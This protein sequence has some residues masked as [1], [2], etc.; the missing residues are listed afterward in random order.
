MADL[1]TLANVKRHLGPEAVAT[2][3]ADA[4]LGSLVTSSSQWVSGRLGRVVLETAFTEVRD[5][6]GGTRMLLDEC[7]PTPDEPTITVT[8]VTVDGET[9][10]ARPAVTLADPNP[11]GWVLRDSGIDLVGYTF[12]VGLRN[13]TIIYRVGYSATTSGTIP[14]APGPYTV[15]AAATWRE[16]IS[17]T[18]AG[19]A[20]TKVTG[21]PAAGQYAVAFS[22]TTG[23]ATYTFN[24]ADTGKAVVLTFGICPTD[25]EQ[26]VIEHVALRYLDRRH[27]G[28]ASAS[29]GVEGSATFGA[30]GLLAYIDGVIDRYR[31]IG[32]G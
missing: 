19:A 4:I 25:L 2:T 28:L 14:A 24:A 27:T 5:G 13:V 7:P 3:E 16:D 29:G 20:A 22:A 18:I 30:V 11:E 21:A 1:T 12:A 10:P 8:S 9:I 23:L 26:A 17:V 32:V 31:A 6:D 15:Q